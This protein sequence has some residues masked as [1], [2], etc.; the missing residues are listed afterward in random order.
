M[1]LRRLTSGC[2][3][4]RIV[5]LPA[6]AALAAVPALA[7]AAAGNPWETM[8]NNMAAA[9][10]GPIGRGLSLVAIVVTGLMFAFG[11]PGGKRALAGVGFGLAMV[12]GAAAWLTWL[13]T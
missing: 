13:T 4:A 6:L 11:E 9:F 12:M 3:G 2:G 10:T 7:G 8:V 5:L 1:S